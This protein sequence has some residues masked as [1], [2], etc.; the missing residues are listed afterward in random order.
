MDDLYVFHPKVAEYDGSWAQRA[1]KSPDSTHRWFLGHR[2]V[3]P[4]WEIGGDFG[5]CGG[6]QL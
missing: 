1:H 5:G 3:R 6:P 2:D 4:E